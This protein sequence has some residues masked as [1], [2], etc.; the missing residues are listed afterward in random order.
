MALCTIVRRRTPRVLRLNRSLRSDA[1]ELFVLKIFAPAPEGVPGFH[2]VRALTVTDVRALP[3]RQLLRA[4]PRIRRLSLVNCDFEIADLFS[5]FA[6]TPDHGVEDLDLSQNQNEKTVTRVGIPRRLSR[7]VASSIEWDDRSFSTFWRAALSQASAPI[8]LDV[9]FAR[10][11]SWTSF[12]GMLATFNTDKLAALRWDE[13]PIG[14]SFS[15]F[16]QRC[17]SFR[18]LSLS[19][20]G[21]VGRDVRRLLLDA[22]LRFLRATTTLAAFGIAGTPL[23]SLSDEAAIEILGRSAQIG[24]LRGS[25]S[26]GINSGMEFWIA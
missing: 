13:C 15:A 14:E 26:T 2:E 17:P 24:R 25:T 6:A 21:C 16:C 12:N 9:S 8:T 20:S 1:V 11:R 18:I 4:L 7:I 23:N 5:I 10:L 3:V 22:P 19:I